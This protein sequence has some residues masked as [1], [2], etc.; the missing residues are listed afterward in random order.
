MELQN[1]TLIVEDA[2]KKPANIGQTGPRH[3]A[4]LFGLQRG[5][6]HEYPVPDVPSVGHGPA[7]KSKSKLYKTEPI[8]PFSKLYDYTLDEMVFGATKTIYFFHYELSA[9]VVH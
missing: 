2:Y 3:P 9:T 7:S 8:L 5:V 1:T 6:V 4:G